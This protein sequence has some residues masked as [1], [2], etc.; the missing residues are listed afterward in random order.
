MPMKISIV[1]PVYNEICTIE[2]IVESI[3]RVPLELEKEIIIVDDFSKDGTRE[4]LKNKIEKKVNKVV[5]FEK[6]MGKG[7]AV[8][9]GLKLATG[10]ITLIQ[11]ADL[12]YHPDEYPQLIKPILEKK[13]DVVFGSRFIGSHRCFLFSHYLGNQVVNFVA[14]ILYNTTL[15]DLM[16]G[17]KVFNAQAL[18]NI[19]IKSNR[20]GFEAEITGIVFKMGLRV[21]EVPISYS[22]RD[23]SEG[24]KIKWTDFFVVI[25]WLLYT[26]MRSVGEVQYITL[27]KLAKRSMRYNQYLYDKINRYMGSRILELG[28]GTGNITCLLVKNRELLYGIEKSQDQLFHLLQRIPESSIFKVVHCDIEK[29][30]LS[31][32]KKINFN[33]VVCINVL[34]HIS[35]HEKLLKDVFGLLPLNGRLILIVPALKGLLSR[36]DRQL[37]HFRRYERKEL[38]NLLRACGFDVEKTEYFNF[39]GIISWW[40]NFVLLKRNGFSSF[41]LIVFDRLIWLVRLLDMFF[42]NTGL[43]L[44]VIAKKGNC[45]KG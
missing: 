44:L 40:F 25:W 36:F 12:E 19:C 22:G 41:Q 18:R 42:K 6:N 1:I 5:Y 34:E 38:E 2:E 8:I 21:Y 37:G 13:A 39:P 4:L 10:D 7:C 15:T 20:F 3:L 14:N 33:T 27:D 24:K 26:K 9:T 23:Y 30:S 16:T 17:Y 32:L 28:A 11:D 45:A 35:D 43:S 29:D 31:Y